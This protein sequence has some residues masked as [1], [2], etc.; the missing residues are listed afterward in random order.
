MEVLLPR[1]L[2]EL[3]RE[4]QQAAKARFLLRLA[5]LYYSEGGKMNVLSTACKLN[6]TTLS[7]LN[8]ISP[9]LAVCLEEVLGADTF[10]RVYFRPDIF[11]APATSAE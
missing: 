3:P 11:A 4:E 1:W 2:E 6:P 9:E 8:S 5:A 7:G 10:P